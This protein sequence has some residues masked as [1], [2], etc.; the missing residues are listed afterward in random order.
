MRGLKTIH[1]RE[2]GEHGEILKGIEEI[3]FDC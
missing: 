3:G 1:H 2:H